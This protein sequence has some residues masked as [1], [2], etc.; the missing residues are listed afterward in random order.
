VRAKED[1]KSESRLFADD[2]VILVNAHP[3]HDW[4]LDAV[5]RRLREELA[6]LQVEIN[7]EKSRIVDL[8]KGESLGFLGFE[9]RRIRSRRGAWRPYYTPKL[10]KRTE[11]VRKLKEIFRRYQSQ[12]VDRVIQLINPILR[13][14]GNYFAIGDSGRCFG[15]LKDWVEKKVRRHLIRAGRRQGF[16][17]KRWSRGWLYEK[18]GLFNNYRVKR[19]KTAL[20][21]LPA[22]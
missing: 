2:L 7:E 11:V 18:L 14:W 17:W 3:R 12:P 22:G 10:K 16:G 8:A 5:E 4:L 21:A 15:Y 19:D 6:K 20:K 1:G 13:G 9:F